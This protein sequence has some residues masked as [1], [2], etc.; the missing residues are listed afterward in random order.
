M[1]IINQGPCVATAPSVM[2]VPHPDL[3]TNLSHGIRLRD[4]GV[5]R[6]GS[7]QGQVQVKKDFSKTDLAARRLGEELG[8]M[9]QKDE[10]ET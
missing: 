2:Y 7:E 4:P 9:I 3:H 1:E 10:G 6:E 5:L 8:S